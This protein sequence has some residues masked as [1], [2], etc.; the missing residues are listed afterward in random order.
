MGPAPNEGTLD[1]LSVPVE[2]YV[3]DTVELAI[4]EIERDKLPLALVL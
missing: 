2:E 1:P 3:A 4:D